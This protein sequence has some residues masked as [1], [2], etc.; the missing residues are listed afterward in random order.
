M[1]TTM[2]R[3]GVCPTLE[4]VT[5]DYLREEWF[6]PER[7]LNEI[8]QRADGFDSDWIPNWTSYLPQFSGGTSLAPAGLQSASAIGW[9]DETVYSSQG[10]DRLEISHPSGSIKIV[11]ADTNQIS[12]KT[13]K[14]TGDS[15]CYTEMGRNGSSFVID[16]SHQTL[17][18][19]NDCNIDMELIVPQAL[20]VDGKIGFSRL[21]L[22]GLEGDLSLNLG[23]GSIY[24][25]VSSQNTHLEL[26]QGVVNLAWDHVDHNGTIDLQAGA[27]TVTLSFPQ[28]TVLN[29]HIKTGLARYSNVLPISQNADFTVTGKVGIGSLTFQYR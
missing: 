23:S 11:G 21:D 24:G 10:I 16:S 19:D 12:V 18:G 25:T 28:G 17:W 2:S 8:R 26:G 13:R 9:D 22:S 3:V 29:P 7:T 5:N 20:A 27:A 6:C 4:K 1:G 14:I 15:N